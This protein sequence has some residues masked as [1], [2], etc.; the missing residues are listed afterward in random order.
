V[1]NA[2][3]LT[4]LGDRQGR[5]CMDGCHVTL[6]CLPPSAC[7][8]PSTAPW[9]HTGKGGGGGG[10]PAFTT[11]TTHRLYLLLAGRNSTCLLAIHLPR[12]TQHWRLYY[13]ARGR[14]IS[15]HYSVCAF[16]LG[17]RQPGA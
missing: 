2:L 12:H 16:W 7:P 6:Y 3:R 17:L 15:W 13:A 11:C 14:G 10:V 5:A 8:L 1:T 4:P 9:H